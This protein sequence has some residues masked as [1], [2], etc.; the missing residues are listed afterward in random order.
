MSL[1]RE[2][3]ELSV[4]VESY[5]EWDKQSH[6]ILA[7]ELAIT[8]A[9]AEKNHQEVL[10][11]FDALRD[12]LS[13]Y[14]TIYKTIKFIAGSVALLVTFKLGDIKLLWHTLFG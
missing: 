5:V 9:M 6:K 2:L 8:K 10:Q 13:I 14:K 1:D 7:D 3:G 11:K 12:E 4:K